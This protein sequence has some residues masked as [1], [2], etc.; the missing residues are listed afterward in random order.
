[1]ICDLKCLLFNPRFGGLH[2]CEGCGASRTGSEGHCP[3]P[4]NTHGF[5]T[6]AQMTTAWASVSS[7]WGWALTPAWR[8]WAFS[9]R[10]SSRAEPPNGM[11][12]ENTSRTTINQSGA[13]PEVR[14]LLGRKSHMAMCWMLVSCDQAS[15]WPSPLLVRRL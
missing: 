4:Q 5:P 13:T 2:W 11:A 15:A 14:L 12:G 1:M 3:H 10:L 6:R 7:G 8:N 9:S